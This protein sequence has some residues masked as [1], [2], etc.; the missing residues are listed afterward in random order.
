MAFRAVGSVRPFTQLRPLGGLLAA[1]L[2]AFSFLLTGFVWAMPQQTPLML[3]MVGTGLLLVFLGLRTPALAVTYLLAATFFRLAIPSGTFPVDPF[4]PAFAG[5]LVSAW[6]WARFRAPARPTLGAIEAAM[7]LYVLWNLVSA[8][9]PHQ[10][11]AVARAGDSLSR[12]ILIGTVMPL[13]MFVVGRVVFRAESALRQLMW[14]L[15]LAGAYSAFVSI[16]QFHFPGVVWP[17]YIV[18]TPAWGDRANGVFNQPV[19]NGLVLIVGFLMA[20][21]IVAHDNEPRIL[22]F[23]AGTV[24]AASAYAIYLTHTRAVWLSFALVVLVGCVSAKGFRAGFVVTAAVITA[25]VTVNWATFASSDRA[26]GGVGSADEVQ[27]RLNTLATSIWAFERKPLLG[28]GIGRF[29]SVNTYHHQ[30]WSPTTPWERGFGI[31]S[32]FDIMGIAVELGVVG[33]ILWVAILYLVIRRVAQAV[34][35]LPEKGVYNRPLAWTALMCLIALITT[36]LTVDL[37]FFDFCN[38]IVWLLAG[39]VVERCERAELQ[40]ESRQGQRSPAPAR[41]PTGAAT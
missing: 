24:S 6:L 4:L 26:A 2:A 37:R 15:V 38:I 1:G 29:S 5:V 9:L 3:A 25:A 11:S 18:D 14:V 30:Q 10:Y 33:V 19:V 20:M 39:A 32:H 23:V 13:S 36:G 21:L 7:G 22:R 34:R 31:P 41:T 12:F 27:D 8:A 17:R 40:A 28:W 16:G 35:R